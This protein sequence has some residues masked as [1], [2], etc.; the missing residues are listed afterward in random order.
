[1]NGQRKQEIGLAILRIV[2]G[3]IFVA[4]GAQKLF[5]FGP[6][7]VGQTFAQMGIPLPTLSAYLATAAEFLGGLA[8]LVGFKTRLAAVPVAFTMLVAIAKVHLKGGF[9]APT[10]FEY[11]LA[12][13]A[14]NVTMIV[15]GGGALAVDSVLGRGAR[16][17]QVVGEAA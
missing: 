13:L 16:N 7:G 4:H 11:P 6:E 5:V 9:F 17:L 1:M 3:A 2:V 8:I 10:G 12:L 15:A 14:A